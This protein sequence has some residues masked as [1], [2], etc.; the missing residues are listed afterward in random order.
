M[1]GELRDNFRQ[2]LSELFLGGNP[3]EDDSS[4]DYPSLAENAEVESPLLDTAQMDDFQPESDFEIADSEPKIP[5]APVSEPIAE[6]A[7]VSTVPSIDDFAQRGADIESQPE[8]EPVAA[9]AAAP[10]PVVVAA[11]PAPEPAPEPAKVSVIDTAAV[12]ASDDP[13]VFSVSDYSSAAADK[14]EV[15]AA[16][17]TPVF[18]VGDYSS[19]SGADT[20]DAGDEAAPIE[21]VRPTIIAEGTEITGEVKLSS[22]AEIYGVLH[23][24]VSSNK[25][26]FTKGSIV[27]DVVAANLDV[28]QTEVRGDVTTS[29]AVRLGNESALIGDVD[30]LRVD[31]RGRLKGNSS[32]A[33]E[34]NVHNTAVLDGNVEAASIAIGHGAKIDG[35]L[36]I[37]G[38]ED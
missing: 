27:G 37:G 10:E 21:Y 11:A 32:V 23:G 33:N 18:S 5:E 26:I 30:A 29:G 22:N 28:L 31:L 12:A 24:N 6:P 20:P 3:K 35:Y 17:D 13:P 1:A 7:F 25:D 34:M 8:P 14:A 38:D 36:N 2:A 19:D 4:E 15:P 16:D 9:P